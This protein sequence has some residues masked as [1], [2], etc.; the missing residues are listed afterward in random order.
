VKEYDTSSSS[1]QLKGQTNIVEE[2]KRIATEIDEKIKKWRMLEE[3][4]N[5]L[6]LHSMTSSPALSV[7]A[8]T[9]S[10]NQSDIDVESQSLVE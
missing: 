4:Q 2:M 7:S 1:Q 6:I 10:D 8:A 5:S 3:K 9:K